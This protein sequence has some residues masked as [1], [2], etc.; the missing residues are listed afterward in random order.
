M[1][2]RLGAWGLLG[3]DLAVAEAD[4]KIKVNEPARDAVDK[5]DPEA[6]DETRSPPEK[7]LHRQASHKRFGLPSLSTKD[8]L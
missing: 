1:T 3:W 7:S 6:V 8:A 5:A 2:L 4:A